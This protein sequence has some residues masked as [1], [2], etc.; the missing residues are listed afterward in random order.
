MLTLGGRLVSAGLMIVQISLWI[1]AVALLERAAAGPVR[2][3]ATLAVA[4]AVASI[5]VLPIR[6]ATR[7]IGR[8]GW[9]G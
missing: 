6:S 9:Y 5:A 2:G 8:L 7:R 4:G 1:T 3:L